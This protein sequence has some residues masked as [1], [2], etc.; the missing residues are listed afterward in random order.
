MSAVSHRRRRLR[1]PIAPMLRLAP[2]S[3]G[4]M[5]AL[6]GLVATALLARL[7]VASAAARRLVPQLAAGHPAG[8]RR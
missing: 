3:A 2:W 6:F 7:V 8:R 1:P 4:A 5:A